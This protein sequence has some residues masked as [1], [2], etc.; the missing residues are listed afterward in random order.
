MHRDSLQHPQHQLS[1]PSSGHWCCGGGRGRSQVP[2][3]CLSETPPPRTRQGRR[4]HVRAAAGSTGCNY[5]KTPWVTGTAAG[6]RRARGHGETQPATLVQMTLI[7]A[8]GPP[9]PQPP[10]TAGHTAGPGPACVRTRLGLPRKLSRHHVGT[11]R[12][13]CGDHLTPTQQCQAVMMQ[14]DAV[15]RMS[16]LVPPGDGVKSTSHT[17]I[18]YCPN[19]T[20]LGKGS[21][22]IASSSNNQ[23]CKQSTT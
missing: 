1:F 16:M 3:K 20:T 9:G 21:R 14:V 4:L 19:L 13:E 12:R 18:T 17:T 11:D 8:A 6:L 15:L 7:E 10:F 2:I 22:K 23:A 5:P